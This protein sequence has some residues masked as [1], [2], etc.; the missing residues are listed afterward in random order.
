V[1]ADQQKSTTVEL[2]AALLILIGLIL[3]VLLADRIEKRRQP[4][5]GDT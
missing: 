2:I 5:W 3:P 1:T 4:N